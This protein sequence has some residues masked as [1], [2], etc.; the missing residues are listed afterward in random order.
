MTRVPRS[1]FWID[2]VKI[3][4]IMAIIAIALFS[5]AMYAPK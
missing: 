3:T 2:L 5:A 4:I 1:S